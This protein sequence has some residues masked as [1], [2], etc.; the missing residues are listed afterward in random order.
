MPS[1]DSPKRDADDQEANEG[2]GDPAPPPLSPATTPADVEELV[3]ELQGDPT[4]LKAAIRHHFLAQWSGPLPPPA[5]IEE[6][7]RIVP[8]SA[9]R[10]MDDF[11]EE[12]RHRRTVE[13][14]TVELR[15]EIVRL[16][17]KRQDRGLWLGF[18][19]AVLFLI[20]AIVLAILDHEL[21][22]IALGG[23]TLAAIVGAF[24]TVGR[25]RDQS[26]PPIPPEDFEE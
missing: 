19:I 21:V 11:F 3:D 17:S 8:G 18:I 12:G 22:A 14:Q 16:D 4:R 6:F 2:Q 13:W 9:T 26:S 1:T 23:G 25:D 20:G 15:G 24:I 5:I 7:D 10:I